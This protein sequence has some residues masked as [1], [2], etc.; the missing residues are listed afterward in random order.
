MREGR[1][2]YSPPIPM[3]SG[4]CPLVTDGGPRALNH[5]SAKAADSA[6]VK[7]ARFANANPAKLA[8]ERSWAVLRCRDRAPARSSVRLRD[9][10][11]PANAM[12]SRETWN[13]QCP[14]LGQYNH[15][16]REPV[17][18]DMPLRG[19]RVRDYRPLLL[20]SHKRH[21]RSRLYR[22]RA[23]SVEG[24]CCLPWNALYTKFRR[25]CCHHAWLRKSPSSRS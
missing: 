19:D 11:P 7:T 8:S 6:G 14:S 5:R 13:C 24:Y 2:G 3:Q 21:S 18:M 9:F 17:R 1:R 16:G 4:N 10:V 25:R 15:L 12:W 20:P 23:C 22:E